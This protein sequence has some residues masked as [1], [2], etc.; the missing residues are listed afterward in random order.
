MFGLI[1]FFLV[2]IGLGH[3]IEP[4]Q[5]FD[6]S[7]IIFITVSLLVFLIG[8]SAGG[9]KEVFEKIKKDKLKTILIPMMS[10]VG[11]ITAGL[12]ISVIFSDLNYIRASLI[13]AGMGYYSLSSILVSAQLGAYMGTLVLMSNILREL[14]VLLFSP[15]LVKYFGKIA[16]I[17][18]G[19]ATTMDVTLPIITKSSGNDYMILAMIN[20]LILSM[21]V[22]VVIGFLLTFAN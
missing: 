8:F 4:L 21:T 22:P 1:I 6:F 14:I 2:G 19:G 5:G 7:N 16:P 10:L 18:A 20:G 11:S 9:N 3:F 12:L 13:T 15:L 17:A